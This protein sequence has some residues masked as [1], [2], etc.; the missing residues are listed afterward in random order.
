VRHDLPSGTVTF[1]FTDV[2]GSTRLLEQL[3]A[4][5]YAEAL[6]RHRDVIRSSL[7]AHGGVEVDTQGDA[8]FCAFSSARA[9]VACAQDAQ[10]RLAE[11]PIR[12]R[13]GV[14]TG[15]ALLARDHYVGLDV[16]RAA[17]IGACAHGGQVVLSP[18]T[19]GLLEP[20]S[21]PL[22]DLGEQRL[23]DL[24]API[25]LYQLGHADFGPLKTL[26]RTN[27]PVVAT[28]FLGRE[29]ELGEL[30]ARASEPGL[31][32][33][34]LT[35]PGGTGKTRCALQLAGELA[36]RF[37]DGVRWA[38]LAALRD[39]GLVAPAV[40]QAVEVEEVPDESMSAAISRSLAAKRLL[41]LL[42][43]CEHVLDAAA[44]V[45]SPLL[46]AC[47]SVLVLATSREPLAL[48][49]EHV[50]PVQPL[51]PPDAVILF[52]AR[53]KAAGAALDRDEHRVTVEALCARLDN[54]PLAVELAAAR[55]AAL[56]PGAILERLSDRLD[57]LK[58]PRDVDERHRTLH[59]AIAWSHDLLDPN[60]QRLFRRFSVFVG[61]ASLE[62]LE[63]IC[64]AD[65][66][67]LL[68]LV[69][70]SLVRQ[71][72]A[73]S[74]EPRYWM[75]ETIREFAAAML[76]DA[77]EATYRERHLEWFATLA[78]DWRER[79]GGPGSAARFERLEQDRENL[80]AAFAWAVA[81][82]EARGE[83]AQGN[84][85]EMAVSIA[86]VL[87]PLHL[88]HGRYAEAEDV[89]RSAL[90]LGPLAPESA[91]LA[92]RL[93]R[94][95]RHRGR[96]DESLDAHLRAERLLGS[97]PPEDADRW[98]RA[99]LD[100]KLEQA[101]HYYYLGDQSALAAAIEELEPH[102][103]RRGTPHQGL[104]FLHVVA[105]AAY[106]RERYELSEETETLL[107]EIYRRS[108]ALDDVD[109][110]FSLGFCLLWRGKFEE[111]KSHF[112][113]GLDS[114]RARGDALIETRCLVYEVVARR[115]QVDV[116]GVRSLLD[117]LD[118]LDELHGYVGLVAANH[119][120][121]ALREGD[122]AA[123]SRYA[124]DAFRDWAASGRSAGPTVFQWTARFPMLGVE[125]A[126]A[127]PDAAFEH[128]E[129]MLDPFQQPLPGELQA[130]L[131]EGVTT[132]DVSS[133]EHALELARASGYA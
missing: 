103:D 131:R 10:S 74:G 90:A 132:R 107:R 117:E 43:N 5:S 46:A 31:R 77:G 110:D 23:K 79:L 37:P 93:G 126:R 76:D 44:G 15:E 80:R 124:E 85:G 60:E 50:Y 34:T 28:E 24:S 129:A 91:L 52:E 101:H 118:R 67:E 51:R 49:G 48:A 108:I 78:R 19:V 38:P 63:A 82:A 32:L 56:P 121:V 20:G 4:E 95:L 111:A 114:A 18:S 40:A 128:A 84:F 27:L 125:L 65:L 72:T 12:V 106:R 14:H 47:P 68:S 120:W 54:L 16:H 58:G 2:E 9:A 62:S 59:G 119:A 21:Y 116:E 35:G 92:S 75:L 29:E 86:A 100:V 109:A 87:A 42:D 30:V 127:R 55:A 69:S 115:R 97:P 70:K 6:D 112:E 39:P 133:L 7:A 22:R 13:M 94:V 53:A 8:F 105:Q 17:R 26:F 1:L 61:G 113:R 33:L 102:V 130:L 89:V 41:L 88:R 66:G 73:A 25:R 11:T 98:W 3:G 104:E 71:H 81:C 123:A 45:V 64:E 36:E 122:L 83:D 96:W 57:V 99:W